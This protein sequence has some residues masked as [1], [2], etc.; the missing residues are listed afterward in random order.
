MR[1][2][3]TGASGFVGAH[4]ARALL[5]Q[6]VEVRALVRPTSDTRNLDG[7]VVEVVHGDLLDGSGLRGL[8]AGCERLYH[9]AAYY[10]TKPE[11][12]PLMYRINVGGTKSLLHAALE[13]GV[14]RV[15]HTSTIG[16]IGRPP[17]DAL[18]TEETEFNLWDTA[19]DYVKSKYL[20]ERAALSMVEQGLDVVVVHPCAPVGTMDIKPTSTG[21]RIVDYLGGKVPSLAS[22]GINFVSVEDVAQGHILAAHKGQTGQ[23]YILGH[24]QGNFTQADFMAMMERA[25]GQRVSIPQPR[26]PLRRLRAWLRPAG[27]RAAPGYRPLALTCDPSRAI[28]EL[29]M[30]QTSLEEAFAAAVAWFTE[31]GYVR[32]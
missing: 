15:V 26:N 19:S 8:M 32:S 9:V 29:G 20:G 11:D 31:K 10:S 3:V 13:A 1:A 30:P 5:D 6:G 4:V 25:S 7:L 14:K 23:R 18:P 16:T 2:F 28:G 17:N 22:G 12:G 24:A 27:K 21:Q